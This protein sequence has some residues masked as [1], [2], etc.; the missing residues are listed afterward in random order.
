M[1]PMVLQLV[2]GRDLALGYRIGVGQRGHVDVWIAEFLFG[3][4]PL[5]ASSFSTV[6]N[7]STGGIFA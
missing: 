2:M 7:A 1:M 6:S 5:E 4:N 3:V